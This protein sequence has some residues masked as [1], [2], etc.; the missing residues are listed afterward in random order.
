MSKVDKITKAGAD[1]VFKMLAF[2]YKPVEKNMLKYMNKKNA[3]WYKGLD[4]AKK[5]FVL[6]KYASKF[7]GL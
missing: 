3:S 4:S 2:Q 1:R 7:L 5:M 6:D